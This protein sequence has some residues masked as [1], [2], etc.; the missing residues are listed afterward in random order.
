MSQTDI[1]L[2]FVQ[3]DI[4]ALCQ[5]ATVLQLHELAKVFFGG[6]DRNFNIFYK[7]VKKYE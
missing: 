1:G 3:G 4:H 7:C 5:Q 6:I 2:P